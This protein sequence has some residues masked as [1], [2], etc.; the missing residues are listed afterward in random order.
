MSEDLDYL[1]EV[2]KNN[3]YVEIVERSGFIT[4]LMMRF[5]IFFDTNSI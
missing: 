2:K 5:Q 4:L 1:E 3:L